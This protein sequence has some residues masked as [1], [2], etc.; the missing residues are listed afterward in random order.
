M[1]SQLE[2]ENSAMKTELKELRSKVSSLLSSEEQLIGKLAS[3]KTALE[4]VG[5]TL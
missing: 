1:L 3:S 4:K 5:S 2:T